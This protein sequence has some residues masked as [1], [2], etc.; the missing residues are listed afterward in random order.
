MKCDTLEKTQKIWYQNNY[1]PSEPIFVPKPGS[2]QEDDGKFSFNW[3]LDNSTQTRDVNN[4]P[5]PISNSDNR[6]SSF[7]EAGLIRMFK[8]ISSNLC[9]CLTR[10][11]KICI[12]DIHT[13]WYWKKLM[14]IFSVIDQSSIM[15][16]IV[17]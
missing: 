15:M 10:W 17:N 6:S 3:S 1:Y 7:L 8:V 5:P 14:S 4:Q 9:V 13:Y 2:T 12:A 11:V 16:M